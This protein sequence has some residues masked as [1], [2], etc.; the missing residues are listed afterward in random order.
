MGVKQ[1]YGAERRHKGK[2]TQWLHTGAGLLHEEMFDIEPDEGGMIPFLQ[3]SSQE[4]YQLWLNVPSSEKM[5]SPEVRLLGGEDGSAPVVEVDGSKTVVVVGEHA[6]ARSAA[7][8]RSDVAV[9]HVTV[10]PG[11][12]WMHDLP[13]SH[14]T[15]IMYMRVGSARVGDT[16]IPVH[17]TAY[18]EPRGSRLVVKADDF[19]GADFLLLA[20]EPLNEP[21]SAQGS[22]VMNYPDEINQAYEDYQVGM[23]GKPWDHKLTDDEWINHIQQNG[24]RYSNS[25]YR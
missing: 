8:P 6:G 14:G 18:M 4:L 5:T 24:S 19:D 23:M 17:H 20:G 25:K 11:S 21:V 12:V 9:L 2:H 1:T 10:E 22:M 16:S 15:V 7:E 13:T 3:P